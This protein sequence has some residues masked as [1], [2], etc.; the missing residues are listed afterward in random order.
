MV[1]YGVLAVEYIE[2]VYKLCVGEVTV[3]YQ[4]VTLSVR[5]STPP[6][7][8]IFGQRPIGEAVGFEPTSNRF[9]SCL[10]I[11]IGQ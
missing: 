5:G 7:H 4:D 3:A 1:K 10:S 8:P 2:E 9:D 11:H 6:R